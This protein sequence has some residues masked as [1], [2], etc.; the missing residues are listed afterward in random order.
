MEY[1]SSEHLGKTLVRTAAF[2]VVFFA[3]LY[4][5]TPF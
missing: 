3:T 2:L 1:L 5:A 4:V